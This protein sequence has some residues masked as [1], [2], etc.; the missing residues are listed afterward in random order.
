[1]QIDGRGGVSFIDKNSFVAGKRMALL[2]AEDAPK[3]EFVA[4]LFNCDHQ[5]AFSIFKI[6]E[7]DY[8]ELKA[9][10][11]YFISYYNFETEFRIKYDASNFVAN[12]KELVIQSAILTALV[13]TTTRK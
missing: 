6:K 1:M 5:E 2:A 11:F 4:A 12:S 3:Y 7:M 10:S 9:K 8:L 13:S